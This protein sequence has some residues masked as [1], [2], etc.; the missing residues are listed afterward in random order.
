M[1]EF[2]RVVVS[3]MSSGRVPRIMAGGLGIYIK[4]FWFGLSGWDFWGFG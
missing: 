2:G 3:L 4:T 1:V